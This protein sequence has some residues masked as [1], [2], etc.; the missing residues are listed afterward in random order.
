[1]KTS[2]AKCA[3]AIR[4]ELKQAFPGVKFYVTSSSVSMGYAVDVIYENAV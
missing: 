1:M 4:K 2:N 3:A